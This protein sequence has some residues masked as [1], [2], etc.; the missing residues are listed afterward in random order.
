MAKSAMDELDEF[1][2]LDH[3]KNGKQN[4]PKVHPV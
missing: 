4:N 2:T 1:A 3:P